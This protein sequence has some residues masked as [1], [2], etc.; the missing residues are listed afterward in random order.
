ML[1]EQAQFVKSKRKASKL[2]YVV[3]AL[4][5]LY[6]VFMAWSAFGWLGIAYLVIV[7]IPLV[8][9]SWMI[10]RSQKKSKNTDIPQLSLWT[11]PI[12]YLSVVF[13]AII[14]FNVVG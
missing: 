11:S 6:M 13:V 9:F 7:P 2:K 14:M 4:I 3:L 5:Y 10:R 1:V 8:F 12:P